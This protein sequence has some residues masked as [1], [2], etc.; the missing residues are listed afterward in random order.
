MEK[1]QEKKL[2]LWTLTG[3]GIGNCVGSGI[4]T[5]MCIAVEATGRSISLA[6]IAGCIVMFFVYGYNTLLAGTF[7]LDGGKYAQSAVLQPPLMLG[8]TA[9]GTFLNG[10]AIA[11]LALS[12]VE[13]A[14]VVFPGL[15]AYEKW[16][17]I[18]IQ[19][20]FFLTTTKGISFMARINS[21]MVAVL[22][23]SLT[24]YSVVG[25]TKL[26]SDPLA[27]CVPGYFRNG[28]FGFVYAIAIMSFACQGATFPIAL[29]KD[30]K[31][32]MRNL[33][34]AIMLCTG[35]I[36]VL[37]A[38]IGA[39]S[40]CILPAEMLEGKNLAVVAREIFPKG[41]FVVFVLGGACMAIATTLYGLIST[42]QYP[43]LAMVKDGWLP[44]FIE[45]KTENGYPWVIYLS[46]YLVGILP[47]FIGMGLDTLIS[48][49]TIPMMVFNAVNNLLV[50]RIPGKYPEVWKKSFFHMPKAGLYLFAGVCFLFSTMIAGCL[51]INLSSRDRV[52]MIAVLLIFFGYSGYRLKS[53][54]VNLVSVEHIRED[55]EE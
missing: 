18:L 37:Y 41:I 20:L 25:L 8:V 12:I 49:M 53:G 52:V 1:V 15:L 36:A 38:V 31:E 43:M 35:I 3:Y 39:V 13:Y 14:G 27:V 11:M 34:K 47:I 44:K 23:L 40:S 30:A 42:V 51:M 54:K 21:I 24:I 45:R 50:L 7:E 19:T 46:M 48:Y 9:I 28:A 6:L 4:F 26:T 16:I 55:V 2:G 33:P 17:A 29:T 22:A 5:S 10:F 32:P